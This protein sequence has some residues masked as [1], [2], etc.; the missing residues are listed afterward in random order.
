MTQR[1]TPLYNLLLISA[2]GDLLSLASP[3]RI[4]QC[5]LLGIDVASWQV[6]QSGYLRSLELR[7]PEEHHRLLI[8]QHIQLCLNKPHG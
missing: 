4:I 1:A 3:A 7:K 6:R 8:E 2:T 5:M